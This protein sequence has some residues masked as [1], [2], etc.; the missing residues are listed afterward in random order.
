MVTLAPYRSLIGALGILGS[1]ALCVRVHH[2]RETGARDSGSCASRIRFVLHRV[3]E[4]AG[5][6]A[7]ALAGRKA[8]LRRQHARQPAR[9]LRRD[10]R[11]A[12]RTPARCRSASSRSRSRR[13]TTT[14]SWVVNHLSDS[15]SIVDVTTAAH[16]RASCARCSS[17]TSR[18]TS[19]FAGPGRQRAFITTAHRGQNIPF[20]PQL[21]TP[22][23]GRADVWVFDADDARRR[24]SAARRS[25][26]SPSSPTR[27][28]RS[29]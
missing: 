26:S 7:R 5:A 11:R 24:R 28:A 13:A 8:A 12:S 3:R 23:V 15:V 22:G 4:R 20:D 16:G 18:A 9:D 14:R 1:R 21:T 29:R 10:A 17:A 6:P 25:R 19:S 2:Q 27:R